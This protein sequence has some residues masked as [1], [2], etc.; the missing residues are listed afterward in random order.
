MKAK[1]SVLIT[2]YNQVKYIEEAVDS[3]YAQKCNFPFEVIVGDDGSDDGSYE[4]LQEKYGGRDDFKII[5]NIHKNTEIPQA[6]SASRMRVELLK[7]VGGEYFLYL[8]GDDFFCDTSKFQKQVEILDA[9]QNL[10]LC[11]SSYYFYNHSSSE[12]ELCTGGL[13]EGEINLKGYWKSKQIHANTCIFRSS[14][15][16]AFPYE[17]VSDVFHD[18]LITFCALLQGNGY[19]MDNPGMC[20]R[21]EDGEC[22]IFLG[23][24]EKVTWIRHTIMTDV[25][26]MIGPQY[27]RESWSRF[28]FFFVELFRHRMELEGDKGLTYWIELA[29][30]LGCQKTLDIVHFSDLRRVRRVQ[31]SFMYLFTEVWDSGMALC[32]NWLAGIKG[33]IGA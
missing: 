7:H 11:G 19:Y 27:H 3:V 10:V 22:H 18:N 26:D 31:V 21:R 1:L 15:I 20:Y 32:R 14:V 29:E 25:C 33:K 5:A 12:K 13:G 16:K 8:D 17:I 23:S 24:N 9:N 30:H 6:T 2:C 4:L 28:R